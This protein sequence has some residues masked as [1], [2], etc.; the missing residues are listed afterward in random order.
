MLRTPEHQF[1]RVALAGAIVALLIG[2]LL[3]LARGLVSVASAPATGA[4]PAALP[5]RGFP[6]AQAAAAPLPTI[7]RRSLASS[8]LPPMAPT[9]Q[10]ARA[11]SPAS[12]D[13]SVGTTRALSTTDM[14]LATQLVRHLA[15]L[16]P[17]AQHDTALDAQAAQMAGREDTSLPL[18]GVIQVEGVD[19]LHILLDADTLADLRGQPTRCGETLI[20]GIPPLTWL[21]ADAHFGLG[22]ATRSNGAV[23]VVA[24]R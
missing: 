23:V 3:W 21:P 12:P 22:V 5:E 18:A 7:A 20:F 24:T 1:L 4:V 19:G 11:S 10:P 2:G 16:A 8:T 13:I 17:Q 9:P 6:L 14:A 15:C